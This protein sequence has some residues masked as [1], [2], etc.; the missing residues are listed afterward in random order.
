MYLFIFAFPFWFNTFGGLILT[1]SPHER[2]RGRRQSR[3]RKAEL[4]IHR[5]GSWKFKKK[6]KKPDSKKN[7]K[8]IPSGTDIE[9]GGGGGSHQSHFLLYILFDSSLVVHKLRNSQ[10][11][12]NKRKTVLGAQWR[13]HS[14]FCSMPNSLGETGS[15]FSGQVFCSLH[16]PRD[17]V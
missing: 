14:N 7:K 1:R 13:T 10:W 6:K 12:Q 15:V 5:H 16:F 3:I 4:F 17:R 2:E 9:A 8:L 11:K